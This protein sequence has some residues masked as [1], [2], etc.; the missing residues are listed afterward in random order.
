M[1]ILITG[2]AGF[3]GKNLVCALNNIKEG[4]DRTRPNLNIEELY[5]YDIDSE[6]SILEEGCEKADFVF[7]FA[8]VICRHLCDGIYA[9]A[10]NYIQ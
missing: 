8:G 5:L 2:A 7:N 10:I 4:K 6:V 9:T 1:K 3:A